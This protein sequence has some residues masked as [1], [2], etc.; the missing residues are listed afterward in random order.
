MIEDRLKPL[1]CKRFLENEHYRKGH[2]NILAPAPGTVILGLHTPEMKSVAKEIAK[3]DYESILKSFKEI[4]IKKGPN[5]LSHEERMIWG[6]ILNYIKCP[7]KKRFSL[8][9]DFVPSID[10]WAICDNF[11]CNSKW[12]PKE[13]KEVIWSHLLKYFH[14]KE[15]FT[16]RT[17]V[18]L[19]MCHY[20]D[21]D[22]IERTFTT[23]DNLNLTDESPY[24]IKMGIAWLL[25]T[26]LAHSQEKTKAFVCRCTLPGSIIKLYIRKA[27]ESRI[28]KEVSPL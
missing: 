26:C 6:L 17:A 20:R 10:N 19:S 1:I 5:G 22:N 21:D 16:V 28:T 23:I 7:L 3:G 27:R 12:V 11:C 8:I 24:Y 15:E 2:I 4:L 18:I 9:D 25:A 13:D 14:S